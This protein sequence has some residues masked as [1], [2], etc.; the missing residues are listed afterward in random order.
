MKA[1][2]TDKGDFT[3]VWLT[4][5]ALYI[6]EKKYKSKEKEWIMI[7][8]KAKSYLKQKGIEKVDAIVNKINISLL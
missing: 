6:L 7:S 8:K 5:L 1:N 2:V 4:I 3:A